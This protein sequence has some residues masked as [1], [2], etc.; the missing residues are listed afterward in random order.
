LNFIATLF[1]SLKIHIQIWW[2]LMLLSIKRK[3]RR[4]ILCGV[5]FLVHYSVW[6]FIISTKFFSCKT[7]FIHIFWSNGTVQTGW[8]LM[9]NSAKL[10][11][12]RF[13]AVA[14]FMVHINFVSCELLLWVFLLK[15]CL[16]ILFNFNSSIYLYNVIKKKTNQ[17][18][19]CK[20]SVIS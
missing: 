10:S 20:L 15:F 6:S 5:K 19:R 11:K 4:R 3:R 18:R 9:L 12:F 8:R 14:N 7:A 16:M 2:C 1:S 13:G 17:S